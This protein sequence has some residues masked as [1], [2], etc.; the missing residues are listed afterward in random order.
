MSRSYKSVWNTALGAWV[1]VSEITRAAGKSGSLKLAVCAVPLI[2]GVAILT[3]SPAI[4]SDVYYLG[5]NVTW[6]QFPGSAW[7]NNSVPNA[8]DRAIFDLA[9]MTSI[10]GTRNVGQLAFLA[11][12]TGSGF[13]VFGPANGNLEGT[14][15]IHGLEGV[16]VDSQVNQQIVLGHKVRLNGNQEWRINSAT[17]S[18]RQLSVATSANLNLGNFILT[19]NAVN[20]ANFFQLDNP[21]TGTG[22]LVAMGLGTVRL[23]D[24]NTYTGGTAINGGNIEIAADN[25][26]GAANGVLSFD[27]GTLHTTANI[28]MNRATTLNAGGGTFDTNAGTTLIQNGV[29]SGTGGLIKTDAGILELTGTNT[30][31]GATSIDAG[32][33]N[34]TGSGNIAESSKVVV[35]GIFNISGIAPV[36]TSIKSLSGNSNGIVTLGSKT[37]TITNANDTFAGSILGTGGLTLS[38]GNQNLTGNNSGFTGTTNVNAGT[39]SVNG[40]LGGTMQVNGGRLQGIGQVGNTTNFAGGTIAPGNSIGTLLIAGNYTGSGGVLEMEGVLA[41]TGSPADRLLI[42][43]NATGNTIVNVINTGGS[44][45]LTGAGNTDGISIIQVGGT[46]TA[47]TFQLA[48]GYAAAGPYQ[49]KL[50]AFDPATSA[51]TEVDPLL[52]API[53]DYRLQSLVDSS[54]KPVAVPQIVGYQAMP[55]GAV[56]YGSSLLDSLHKRL[57]EIRETST[58]QNQIGS[59]EQRSKEVF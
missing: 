14:L 35:N 45:A 4:A 55:T 23:T 47:S 17:G 27:G 37:L 44:G 57:G 58:L 32:T 8:T 1:A 10:S 39:L 15:T 5:G 18:I 20:A 59:T 7:S 31:T 43:G 54:G 51:A 52:A 9:G 13:V 48:G 56:R 49:Y 19:L 46:S 40:I 28:T 38:G 22:G 30:Y 26:L 21:I 42:T 29:F 36:D 41:G 24:I 33:L 11:P 6:A 2:M 16:G 25:N 53:W 34:L 12:Y 3:A 50:T